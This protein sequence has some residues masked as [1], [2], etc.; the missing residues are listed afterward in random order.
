MTPGDASRAPIPAAF[1]HAVK[2]GWSF[3]QHARHVCTAVGY[4]VG[5]LHSPTGGQEREPEEAQVP[6]AR[7]E[8]RRERKARAG[9]RRCMIGKI[10]FG[11]LGGEV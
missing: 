8:G 2:H 7:A 4:L 9:V 3:R 1:R 6:A 11:D 5:L 10:A